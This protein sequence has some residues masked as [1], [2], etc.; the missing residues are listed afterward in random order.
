[1]RL[2]RKVYFWPEPS[3]CVIFCDYA[4]FWKHQI[5]GTQFQAGGGRI[6]SWALVY[7][8][9]ATET[10]S[11]MLG[12]CLV[13]WRVSTPIYIL[14]WYPFPSPRS[15]SGRGGIDRGGDTS[16]YHTKLQNILQ[17]PTTLN[18]AP[19]HYTKT[20]KDFT[21]RHSIFVETPNILYKQLQ[22][23]TRVAAHI[24]FNIQYQML[25]TVKVN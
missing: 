7:T 24:N 14:T 1:M 16:G 11:S 4:Y 18:K 8:R 6:L 9:L 20:Y 19:K 3:F 13:S 21:T 10:M 17:S 23:P 25:K 5:R 2:F 15:P 22:C 12:L